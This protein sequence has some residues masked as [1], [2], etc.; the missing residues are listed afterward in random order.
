M[1]ASKIVAPLVTEN[2]LNGIIYKLKTEFGIKP[3]E[4]EYVIPT[5]NGDSGWGV[6]DNIV[7]WDSLVY[8]TA[9]GSSSNPP[10][11]QLTFTKGYIFPNAYSMRGV[12][13]SSTAFNFA[14]SWN[15][16]GIHEGDESNDNKWDLLGVNDT[17]ESTFCNTLHNKV[18]C[19]DSRVGTFTLKPMPSSVGYKAMRWKYKT[20]PSNTYI[21][22]TSGIDVYG[23]LSI[24]SSLKNNRKK[25]SCYC[26]CSAS[27]FIIT[28]MFGN[29]MIN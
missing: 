12:Y 5:S 13:T 3:I 17:S 6:V 23:T 7:N 2:E 28:I 16:Y 27:H 4:D 29:M 10:W 26:K 22:A 14:N 8:T 24:S 9:S 18:Y 21:F 15:V 19:D 20:S 11:V 1:I 25:A